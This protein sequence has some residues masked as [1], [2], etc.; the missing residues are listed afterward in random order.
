[1]PSAGSHQTLWTPNPPELSATLSSLSLHPPSRY[2]STPPPSRYPT[3]T[4][5]PKSGRASPRPGPPSRNPQEEL[6]KSLNFLYHH[7]FLQTA[8]APVDHNQAVASLS[9]D[10][11]KRIRLY[12]RDR[13]SPLSPLC[14]LYDCHV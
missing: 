10:K 11:C 12:V 9:G 6:E 13:A 5:P 1:M 8:S 7:A 3:P 14:D 2:K 4:R